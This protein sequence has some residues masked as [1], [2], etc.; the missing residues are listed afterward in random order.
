MA[1]D[2]LFALADK[3]KELKDRKKTLEEEVKTVNAEIEATDLALSDLMAD[4]EV[5]KFSRSGNLF[6]LKTA[7]H[8][9]PLAGQKDELFAA[10]RSHGYGD[11]VV[12]TVNARTLDSFVKEQ[13][14]SNEDVLPDWL[15]QVVS[16]YEKTSVGV[17]KG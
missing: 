12:E 10:L 14:A 4:A 3:L 11:L 8:A 5:Q 16:T 13:V 15:S 6:Y 17:R 1:D 9:S 7:I 2:R